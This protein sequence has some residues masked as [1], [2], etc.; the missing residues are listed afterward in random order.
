MLIVTKALPVPHP[1]PHRELTLSQERCAP[2]SAEL[3][4]HPLVLVTHRASEPA[5]KLHLPAAALTP[6]TLRRAGGLLG[7]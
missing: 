5:M 3:E 6:T 2:L 4:F 7:Q 1:H